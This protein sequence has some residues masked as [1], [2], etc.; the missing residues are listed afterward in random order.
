VLENKV[1]NVEDLRGRSRAEDT[2]RE[3]VR[4]YRDTIRPARERI[5]SGPGP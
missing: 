2:I 4:L 5:G 3:A 1:V